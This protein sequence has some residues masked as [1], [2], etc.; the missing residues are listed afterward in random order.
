MRTEDTAILARAGLALRLQDDRACAV[1]KQN[2][3]TAVAPIKDAGKGLRADHQR[4]LEC[5]RLEQA[6]DGRET[7]DEAGTYGL[8]IEGRTSGNA[9]TCL[10]GYCGRREGIVRRGRR[11]HD[12][13][14][15]L[16]IDAGSGKRRAGGR[17]GHVRR[18]FPVRRDAPLANTG[19][20]NNPFVGG[21]HHPRQLGIGEHPARQITAAA[22]YHG[23]QHGHEAA[24]LTARAGGASLRWRV[25]LWPI[26]ASNSWRTMS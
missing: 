15:R 9:E 12:Q 14:Y 16:G 1:A 2:A 4:T 10:Y 24:P 25:R 18:G 6:I 5:A 8:Q 22:E 26:L 19:A 3:G 7:K 20:L 21:V 17:K 23:P 11:E 13:V